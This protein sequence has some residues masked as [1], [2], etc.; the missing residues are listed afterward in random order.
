MRGFF[1][2]DSASHTER[3]LVEQIGARTIRA[4]FRYSLQ[5]LVE[6]PISPLGDVEVLRSIEYGSGSKK[7]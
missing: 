1:L 6:L 2:Q 3:N 7:K 4:G 5:R